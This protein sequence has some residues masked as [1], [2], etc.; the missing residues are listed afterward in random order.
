[1]EFFSNTIIGL[2]YIFYRNFPLIYEY[3]FEILIG[4]NYILVLQ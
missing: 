2:C 3:I 4:E 1:M